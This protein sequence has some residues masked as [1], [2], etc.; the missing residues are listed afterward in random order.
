MLDLARARH[1]TLQF[2]SSMVVPL[3]ERRA[4]ELGP[5]LEDARLPPGC[6]SEVALRAFRRRVYGVLLSRPR[7]RPAGPVAASQPVTEYIVPSV[8]PGTRLKPMVV[9]PEEPPGESMPP[10]R[11]GIYTLQPCNPTI[12]SITLDYSSKLSRLS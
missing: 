8:P 7:P 4:L 5:C 3:L 12:T 6:S 1:G 10:T 2:V 9:E 11:G